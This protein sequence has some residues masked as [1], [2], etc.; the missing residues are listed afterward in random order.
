MSFNIDVS[1]LK[2]VILSSQKHWHALMFYLMYT[3]DD[4]QEEWLKH[5]ATLNAV[6]MLCQMVDVSFLFIWF[7]T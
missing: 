1:T 2:I 4:G 5:V 6:Q 3:T 7:L